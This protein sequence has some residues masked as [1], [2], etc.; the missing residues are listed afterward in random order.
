MKN[1]TELMDIKLISA[2]V[3][4]ASKNYCNSVQWVSLHLRHYKQYQDTTIL[5]NPHLQVGICWNKFCRLTSESLCLLIENL[6]QN[7][8]S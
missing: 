4:K 8:G 7:L 1:I 2:N 6:E 3:D 5:K